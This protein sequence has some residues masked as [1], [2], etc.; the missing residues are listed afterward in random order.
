MDQ[1]ITA[2]RVFSRLALGGVLLLAGGVVAPHAGAQ[3]HVNTPDVQV[4]SPYINAAKPG[5][6]DYVHGLTM[7]QVAKRF[8]QP[9]KKL[10]AVP[11][12]GGKYHPPITRWAYPG[13]TVYFERSIAL[14][15]VRHHPKPHK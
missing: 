15:L 5:S 14:H 4:M 10:A 7:A 2:H 9:Q 11:P 1:R 6:K 13:F 3:G 8:G 12:K